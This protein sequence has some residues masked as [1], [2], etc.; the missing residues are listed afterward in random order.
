VHLVGDLVVTTEQGD[1]LASSLDLS[2]GPYELTLSP[3]E[4]GGW[5]V[6][7]R[8]QSRSI[9]DLLLGDG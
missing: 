3:T 9:G 8:V 1:Q 4:G 7:G 6:S 5:T 2:N